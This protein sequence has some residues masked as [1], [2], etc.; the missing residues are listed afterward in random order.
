[1]MI[2]VFKK[3][4][5]HNKQYFND[6]QIKKVRQNHEKKTKK[7]NS[8]IKNFV[9]PKEATNPSSNRKR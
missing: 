9:H 6:N 5:K 7:K 1:M 8:K 4:K 2:I 3:F